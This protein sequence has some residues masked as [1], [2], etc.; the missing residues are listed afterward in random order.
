MV[1]IKRLLLHFAIGAQNF[2]RYV[3]MFERS[4]GMITADEQQQE[5]DFDSVVSNFHFAFAGDLHDT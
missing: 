3:A 2:F 5:S 4:V 1:G